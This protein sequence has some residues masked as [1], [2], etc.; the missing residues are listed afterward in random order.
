MPRKKDEIYLPHV[1][2]LTYEAGDDVLRS[3]REGW[4]EYREQAFLWLYLR[5]GDVVVDC[6][7]H[8]GLYSTL[9]AAILHN[10]GTVIAIEPHPTTATLLSRN[11]HSCNATCAIVV[12]AALSSSEGTA[13]LYP[14]GP[15]KSAYS[16]MFP[17]ETGVS[18]FQ[19]RT[20]TVDSVCEEQRLE[21]IDFLKVDAEGSELQVLEGASR[22]IRKQQLPVVMVEF[23][24]ANLVRAG[25]D[26]K[27][28]FEEI[29]S[30]GYVICRFDQKLCQLA[31]IQYEAP[32]GYENYFAT[33]DLLMVNRRLREAPAQRQRIAHELLQRGALCNEQAGR[34]GTMEGE[35]NDLAAQLADLRGHFDESEADRAARLKLIEEQ[36]GRLGTMEGERNDLAA[37]L[38]DLRGHFDESEA[39]RAARLEVIEEQDHLLNN[40]LASI[41]DISSF[42]R[43]LE[44][45]RLG[46]LLYFLRLIDFPPLPAIQRSPV[47]RPLDYP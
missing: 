13:S 26:T 1:G 25:L 36:A 2:W 15:T 40:Q 9:S 6:G 41:R 34:L 5:D 11:L 14:G 7:A 38:A 39:D 18:G 31:A 45:S 4:F 47:A 3:L 22:T 44:K 16:S 32:V 30:R 35:R 8:A 24:E 37:Q 20:T 19:V 29:L 12:E 10:K 23:T 46:R 27:K 43:G 17:I 21:R 28:L 42:I 33:T